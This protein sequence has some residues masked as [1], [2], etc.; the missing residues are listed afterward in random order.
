VLAQREAQE[1]KFEKHNKQ[2][3]K[4]DNRFRASMNGGKARAERAHRHNAIDCAPLGRRPPRADGNLLRRLG[5]K[6]AT[7]D[8]G[9]MVKF[10]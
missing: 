4:A 3:E 7:R 2:Y 8:Y 10:E 5:A 6:R 9:D 1:M